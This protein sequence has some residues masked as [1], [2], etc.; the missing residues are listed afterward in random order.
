MN[1]SNSIWKIELRSRLNHPGS[2]VG[3]DSRTFTRP[4]IFSALAA[5]ARCITAPAASGKSTRIPGLTSAAAS[6]AEIVRD[7]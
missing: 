1:N 4:P 2:T 7:R 3:D 5:S 6:S